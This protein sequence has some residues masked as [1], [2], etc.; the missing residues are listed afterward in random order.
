MSVCTHRCLVCCWNFETHKSVVAGVRVAC[1]PLDISLN[2]HHFVECYLHLHIFETILKCG[3]SILLMFRRSCC[4]T[5]PLRGGSYRWLSRDC[6]VLGKHFHS[7]IG[8]SKMPQGPGNESQLLVCCGQGTSLWPPGNKI[9]CLWKNFLYKKKKIN[10]MLFY[11]KKSEKIRSYFRSK[12]S[13]CW[14]LGP[15]TFFIKMKR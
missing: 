10:L 6:P 5:C 14:R 9:F 2:R 4:G 13:S 15:R 11:R 8:T 7:V 3:M 12:T 1:L